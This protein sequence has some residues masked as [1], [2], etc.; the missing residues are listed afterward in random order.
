M[1]KGALMLAL[2]SAAFAGNAGASAGRIDFSI[3]GVVA[4]RP[5]GQE[6][7][8]SKGSELESGD[9]IR[10]NDGRA[11]IRFPDGAYVSLQP[12]TIFGVR[13]YNYE[14][15][16]DG[17]ERGFFSLLKGAMRA[18]TGLIGR[19]NRSTFQITTPT[20]TVGIRGTGGLIAVLPDGSTLIRGSS[21]I[22]SLTNA[23]GSIDVPAG[24]SGLAPADPNQPPQETSGIPQVPPAPPFAFVSGDLRTSTGDPLVPLVPSQSGSGY[25][26]ALAYSFYGSGYLDASGSATAVF[27]SAG[28]L[29]SVGGPGLGS[30]GDFV[31][32]N[33]TVVESGNDGIIAWGRWIGDALLP[34]DGAL[35]YTFDN[36]QSLH[37]V[38]GTP[39]PVMPT[40]GSAIFTLL[41]ATSPTYADGRTRPGTF[42]GSLEVFFGPSAATVN[43]AF[44]VNMPDGNGYAIGGSTT[45]GPGAMFSANPTVVGTAGGACGSG[46]N[47]SVQGFFAGTNAARA[48][49][50]YS[51]QDYQLT[52]GSGNIVGAAAFKN[53][54]VPVPPQ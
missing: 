35:S 54:G 27:N 46:C 48:G 5:D 38:I 31:L 7:A 16:T 20:A 52:G 15:K 13:E 29:T 17:K 49:V 43:M 26:A 18:V 39:T 14:G 12:N 50:G 28:Q 33:G 25:A 45:T 3:G 1:N 10:T 22:W 4:T 40:T 19:V 32:V 30:G 51:I 53:T 9:T 42:N 6:R 23:S 44:A 47:A 11:Q 41:G 37:Y 21:G 34:L 2:V 36:N 8:L 24:A